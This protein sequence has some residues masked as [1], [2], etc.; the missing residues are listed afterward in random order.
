M[1]QRPT[2]PYIISSLLAAS[3]LLASLAL[4]FDPDPFASGAAA[5]IAIGLL[6]YTVIA[7]AGMLLVKAPWARWLGLGATIGAVVVTA[8]TGFDSPWVLLIIGTSLIAIAALAGPLLTLW[9]RQRPGAGPEPKA[10][11]LPLVALGAAPVAGFAAW[12]GLSAPVLLAAVLGTVAAWSYS[13]AWGWGLW[14]LRAAYPITAVVAATQ[15]GWAGAILFAGHGLVV[16]LLAWSPEASR[17]QR[18]IAAAFPAPRY[19]RR[20]P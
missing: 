10:V 18:P 14:A 17:A 20:T 4:L 19:R 7:V 16:A 11:A 12:S 3:S 8:I 5:L 6:G 15:V 2:A 13:R 9:L 1:A